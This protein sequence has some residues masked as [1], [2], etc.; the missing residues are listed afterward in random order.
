MESNGGHAWTFSG[1][2]Y[3]NS[4]PAPPPPPPT[5]EPV[6]G[7]VVG[8]PEPSVDTGKKIVLSPKKLQFFSI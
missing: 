4:P 5:R 2:E 6:F 8:M 1:Y 7:R 3:E